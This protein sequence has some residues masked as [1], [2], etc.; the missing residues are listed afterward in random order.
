[1]LKV[2][3]DVMQ[4]TK[5]SQEEGN[6]L[7][8][9]EEAEKMANKI[10]ITD[11]NETQGTQKN[12]TT[13]KVES[14]PVK[15]NENDPFEIEDS[16]PTQEMESEHPQA[17]ESETA[18]KN[19]NEPANQD[20]LL[21]QKRLLNTFLKERN[22]KRSVRTEEDIVV[23][24]WDL[25]GQRIYHFTHHIYFSDRCMYLLLFDLR[26]GLHTA[27]DDDSLVSGESNF[28]TSLGKY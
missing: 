20:I 8:E 27:V 24:G 19:E 16:E 23:D 15:T 18:Q 21:Q 13:K 6:V 5:R 2:L 28:S 9:T 12:E 14:E 4:A 25:A 26:M 1:M 22:A 3:F 7:Q 17:I 10:S 11:E